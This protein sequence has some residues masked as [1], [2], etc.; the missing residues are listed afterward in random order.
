[1][2]RYAGREY[3]L[4]TPD[5]AAGAAMPVR[6][7]RPGPQAA[8]S[9]RLQKHKAR[10]ASAT[11]CRRR[12]AQ[13]SVLERKG[14]GDLAR[15]KRQRISDM[16]HGRQINVGLTR[17]HKIGH[18]FIQRRIL[19]H[20]AVFERNFDV[21]HLKAVAAHP[22][23]HRAVRGLDLDVPGLRA[24]LAPVEIGGDVLG[25]CQPC[26]NRGLAVFWKLQR[27]GGQVHRAGQNLGQDR[28]RIDAGIK[29]AHATGRTRGKK[30]VVLVG[31]KKAVAIAVKNVSGRRRW[32]KLDEWL[33]CDLRI[34]SEQT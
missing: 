3:R 24:G 20:D 8:K 14:V 21:A 32:S 7:Q 23:G 30:L 28:Q 18:A 34:G 10:P 25:E 4:Q 13:A 5:E 12:A 29:H 17:R 2:R 19:A 33:A 15:A 1:M 31:Q 11:A 9:C 6:D 27:R 22:Q 26:G 16:D